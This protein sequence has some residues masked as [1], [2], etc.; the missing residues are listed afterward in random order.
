MATNN[1]TKNNSQELIGALL[2]ASIH[3]I[4]NRFGVLYNQLDGLLAELPV[5][6]QQQEKSDR[7]K[8]EAEFI[9]NELIRVLASYKSIGED[10]FINI[11]Q[12]IVIEFLEDTVA[13]HSYTQKANSLTIDFDCDEDLTGFYDS[14]IL[15]IVLDTGIYNSVKAGA[16][17]ILLTANEE[18]PGYLSLH[19]EDNGPGFPDE[20]LTQD[21]SQGK[22]SLEDQSTGL[23]LFFANQ[24]IQSHTE[25]DKVGYLELGKGSRLTGAKLSFYIPQ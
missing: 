11:D 5:N 24:L 14:Q 4:K 13:R 9:S 16:N 18:T 7:I 23:G 19:I 3:E 8:S 17:Q 21:I 1:E 25:G 6:P 2:A 20:F 12:H 22:L 15:T 10:A